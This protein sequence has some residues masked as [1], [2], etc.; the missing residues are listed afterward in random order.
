[1]IVYTY[2]G[3]SLLWSFSGLDQSDLNS[4]V[5]ILVGLNVLHFTVLEII[6]DCPR[7]T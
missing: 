3:T 4:Q 1:M 5:T 2:S 7:V 6:W